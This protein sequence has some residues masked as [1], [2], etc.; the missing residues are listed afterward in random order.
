[1]TSMT[2]LET[3]YNKFNEEKRLL[4]PYGQVEYRTSM[5]Y[6]RKCLETLTEEMCKCGSQGDMSDADTAEPRK[7]RTPLRIADLGAGTG[8]YALPLAAE[9]HD[10]TA[11]ELVN[12]N[13]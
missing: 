9:G 4:R 10:V 12:Y 5:V 7:V 8:R 1:M 13:L 2:D 3:Y 6:I 11:V